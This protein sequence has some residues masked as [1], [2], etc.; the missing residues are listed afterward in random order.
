MNEKQMESLIEMTDTLDE[1]YTNEKFEVAKRKLK[2]L[3]M[4]SILPTL[5]TSYSKRL[6]SIQGEIEKRLYQDQTMEELLA[7]KVEATKI[8]H[9]LSVEDDGVFYE[10]GESSLFHEPKSRAEQILD[11]IQNRLLNKLNLLLTVPLDKMK[12]ETENCKNIQE[13]DKLEEDS[14]NLFKSFLKYGLV[15]GKENVSIDFESNVINLQNDDLRRFQ[16]VI[17]MINKLKETLIEKRK[18]LILDQRKTEMRS[19]LKSYGKILN[20]IQE[21]EFN[22]DTPTKIKKEISEL[23]ETLKKSESMKSLLEEVEELEQKATENIQKCKKNKRDM[24]LEVVSAVALGAVGVVGG[25]PGTSARGIARA[26][27]RAVAHINL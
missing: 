12:R 21:T 18:K 6:N 9:D 2:R 15:I 5:L 13:V 4:E 11:Q 20:S 1:S 25:L 23:H 7:F 24:L 8:D 10:A 3:R 17:E 22:V 26:F 27:G 16:N 19:K 14:N